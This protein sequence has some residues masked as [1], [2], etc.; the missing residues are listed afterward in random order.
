MFSWMVQISPSRHQ[1]PFKH[2]THT[3]TLPIAGTLNVLI[4]EASYTAQY[5]GHGKSKVAFELTAVTANDPHGSGSG[6]SGQIL[7]LCAVP[8]LEPGIFTMLCVT[9]VYPTTNVMN[10][11][12]EYDRYGQFVKDWYCWISEKT[13]PLDQVLVQKDVSEQAKHFFLLGCIRAMLRAGIQGHSVSDNGMF[14]F[15]LRMRGND[16]LII[17]AGSR[18]DQI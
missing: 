12:S 3:R 16:V 1:L 17:D 14:K 4:D 9:D 6:F 8:D 11:C 13:W 2:L 15:G 18:H 7:K 5:V 10:R